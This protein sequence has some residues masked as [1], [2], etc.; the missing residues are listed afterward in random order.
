MWNGVNG[1]NGVNGWKLW[2]CA[3]LDAD[4]HEAITIVVQRRVDHRGRVSVVGKAWMPSS[5]ALH[6]LLTLHTGTT[7]RLKRIQGTGNGITKLQGGR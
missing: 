7:E 1:V 2:K 6:A 4:L 3:D 5:Q